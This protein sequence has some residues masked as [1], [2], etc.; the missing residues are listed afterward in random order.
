[1]SKNYN[2]DLFMEKLFI[3]LPKELQIKILLFIPSWKPPKPKFKI[4]TLVEYSLEKKQNIYLRIDELASLTNF[5]KN[6]AFTILKIGN[7]PTWD[8]KKKDW[9]YLVLYG[10]AGRT[11]NLVFEKDLILYKKDK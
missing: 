1:M 10:P 4:N 9:L 6:S 2:R 8:R 5:S 11:T 3:H 7:N